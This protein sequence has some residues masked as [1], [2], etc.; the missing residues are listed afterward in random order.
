[1]SPHLTGWLMITSGAAIALGAAVLLASRRRRDRA[2]AAAVGQSI[3][4]EGLA[5][6][7]H[8]LALDEQLTT[9]AEEVAMLESWYATESA[10]EPS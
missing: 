6:I 1:M 4:G 10:E 9:R 2:W 5:W 3:R 7:E 8:L